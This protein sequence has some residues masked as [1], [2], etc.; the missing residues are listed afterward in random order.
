VAYRSGVAVS[1]TTEDTSRD[2]EVGQQLPDE[3]VHPTI[4]LTAAER[5]FVRWLL[6]EE[7]RRWMR[8]HE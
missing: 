6:R 5:D 3:S 4:P 7:I 1:V 8:E 2:D